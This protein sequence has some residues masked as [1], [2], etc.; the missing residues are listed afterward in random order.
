[1]TLSN[2][3]RDA[4]PRVAVPRVAIVGGGFAG[5]AFAIHL[6]RANGRRPLAIDLYEPR[7]L[8]GAGL[9]YGTDDDAHRI[10]VAAAR[11]AL[12]SE[13][14]TH[15][16]RWFRETGEAEADPEAL[17]ADGRAYPRRAAFGRYV[18]H[19]LRTAARAHRNIAFRH[20]AARVI[21]VAPAG[22]GYTL[23]TDAG[24]ALP[25]DIVVLSPGHPAPALPRWVGAEAAGHPRFIADPWKSG[26]LKAV[27]PEDAVLIVGT[28]LTMADVVASLQKQ[29]HRGAITAVSRRGL[30]PRPRTLL[31]VEAFGRFDE[32]PTDSAATL[33]LH[34]RRA[35]EAA[36]AQGRPWECVIDALRQQGTGI[37]QGLSPASRKRFLRH[38][39]PWWDVHRYQIAPQIDAVL[40]AAQRG[41]RLAIVKADIRDIARFEGSFHARLHLRGRARYPDVERFFDA[42][43][44]CTGPDHGSVVA[45]NPVLRALAGRA[46]LKSDPLGLGIAVDLSAQVLD[47][48]DRPVPGLYVA[49]PLARGTFGELMGLPQV[50]LQPERLANHIAALLPEATAL[51]RA[52]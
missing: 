44:N 4:V 22:S 37:W 52:V 41:G 28:G 24:E 6:I 34:V 13:D 16:D 27:R 26:A 25:A 31:P 35:V 3:R 29:G 30:T 33:L 21:D 39:R 1:V 46:L 7:A 48:A 51:D 11:M 12:F 32:V 45:G 17:L 43:V 15:F 42:V 49:G 38:L 50:S 18:D 19:V 2:D 23:T 14:P 8:L 47:A 10:N 9:A 20:V 36:A 40:A 5:A